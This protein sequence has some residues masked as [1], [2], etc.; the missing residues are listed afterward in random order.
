MQVGGNPAIHLYEI[1]GARS[2]L[3]VDGNKD[4]LDWPVPSHG[5]HCSSERSLMTT[6]N[7]TDKKLIRLGGCA[8][9]NSSAIYDTNDPHGLMHRKT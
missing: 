8:G 6:C 3:S 2:G 1:H 9:Q 5:L 4:D 7:S